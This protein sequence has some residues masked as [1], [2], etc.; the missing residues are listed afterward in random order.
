MK[1][2]LISLLKKYGINV[3][4]LVKANS[5]LS[6]NLS[7]VR[8]SLNDL[9][10]KY[11]TD[12]HSISNLN[13]NISF[14]KD[15]NVKL[16]NELEKEKSAKVKLKSTLTTLKQAKYALAFLLRE[17][18]SRESELKLESYSLTQEISL[19]KEKNV[20]LERDVAEKACND[21]EI[22]SQANDE[23]ENFKLQ[24]Q[25]LKSRCD[26]L[27]G[28]E[29]SLKGK[30]SGLQS[31]I[32]T[33]Q[34]QLKVKSEAI[35]QK[36]YEII[37]I[38][39][40]LDVYETPKEEKKVFPITIESESTTGVHIN[41]VSLADAYLSENES[42][43]TEP[44]N[45]GV[46]VVVEVSTKKDISAEKFFSLPE[47]IIFRM[48]YALEKGIYLGS[49]LL[50]CKH[51]GQPVRISGEKF[52]RGN[53]RFFSHVHDT[54]KC[55][56]TKTG[57]TVKEINRE[58]FA[59]NNEGDRH[60][61]LKREI[62]DLLTSTPGIS[63]VIVE[64]TVKAQSH[65]ILRWRRPDIQAQYNGKNLV[66]EVQLSTTFSS[67]MVERDLFYRMEQKH[68]LWIF[69]FDEQAKHVDL[70]NM[71]SKDAYLNNRFN[72]FLFDKEARRK[73]KE[74]GQLY[75]KCN[76]IVPTE[77]GYTWKYPNGN[78]AD[79]IG[80]ELI[81]L[82]DI[83][84]DDTYKPYYYDAER[85]YYACHPEY[86]VQVESIDSE[87]KEIIKELDEALDRQEE[88]KETELQNIKEKKEG[89]IENN[90]IDEVVKSTQTYIIGK[91]RGKCGLITLDGVIR[92][93]FIYDEINT[94]GLMF[95]RR[96]HRGWIEARKNDII[97]IYDSNF[98]KIDEVL[99]LED[100]SGK[101]KKYVKN[102]HGVMLWGILDSRGESVTKPVYS[103]MS[104]WTSDKVLVLYKGKYSIISLDGSVI[105]SGYDKIGSLDENG[106]AEIKKDGRDGRINC[107]C[108][109]AETEVIDLDN[110]YSK[111]C[112]TERY[113]IK[114]GSGQII[115]PCSYD[116]IGSY[117]NIAAGVD[118]LNVEIIKSNLPVDCPVKVSFDSQNERKML[119]F[120]IG[121]RKAF[122]NIRQQQ[123]AKENGMDPKAITEAYISFVNPEKNLLYLS[124]IPIKVTSTDTKNV[125]DSDIPLGT[126]ADGMV[127]YVGMD[128]I[129][130]KSEKIGKIYVH[131]SMYGQYKKFSK[132]D[133]IQI[134]K[135]GFD[136]KHNKHNWEIISIKRK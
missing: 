72:I 53:A 77:E 97:K 4:E 48:R 43:P 67:V 113:G 99:G 95:D 120:N 60:K 24:I 115:I 36:D 33:L 76:W 40:R 35:T 21:T 39:E 11:E 111:I 75:L 121:R 8:L 37:R 47:T 46:P 96:S 16:L 90:E 117:K 2:L 93:P 122:M 20:Q 69:N 102:I 112:I 134:R 25:E 55:I 10:K 5:D 14:F 71:M 114:N 91:F 56:K 44:F 124:A 23:I 45:K 50:I 26:Y 7:A 133:N 129:I 17:S 66:F 61:R 83:N 49:P 84:F 135:T 65:P 22:N 32:V 86:K 100:L 74:T 87:N 64:K 3:E 15:E 107:E 126:V 116:D 57:R 130:L 29:N 103:G 98:N 51:C 94:H 109:E 82:S 80:G 127:S 123:K 28:Q 110:G 30:I 70:T 89:I 104:M 101:Y 42:C 13:S 119:I 78:N 12:E 68:I 31:T 52:H 136:I 73:S 128:Y 34:G 6:R 92:L 58:K 18:E 41:N 108:K 19:L 54:D 118:D 131:K 1:K 79:E 132:G 62:A 38:R 88:K 81:T 85:E 9:N 59:E 63:N 105:T 106:F 27:T 125:L